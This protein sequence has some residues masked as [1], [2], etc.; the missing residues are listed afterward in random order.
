MVSKRSRKPRSSKRSSRRSRISKKEKTLPKTAKLPSKNSVAR[1]KF[2]KAH[3][4]MTITEL[5]FM[6]KSRGIPFMGLSKNRL[7]HKINAY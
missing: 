3:S 7:V 5:Q 1:R 4:T 2:S 6:A